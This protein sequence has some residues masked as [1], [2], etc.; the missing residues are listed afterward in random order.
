M[1]MVRNELRRQRIELSKRI[2]AL[3]DSGMSPE[4][5]SQKMIELDAEMEELELLERELCNE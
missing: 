5:I 1:S 2:R 4:I 3:N